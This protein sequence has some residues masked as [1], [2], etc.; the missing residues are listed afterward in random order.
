MITQSD[1][2]DPEP[3]FKKCTNNSECILFL[4]TFIGG[5]ATMFILDFYLGKK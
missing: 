2:I 3:C 4:L 1:N 5:G